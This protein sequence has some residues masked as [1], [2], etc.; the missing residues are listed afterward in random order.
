MK[1][2]TKS[3]KKKLKRILKELDYYID[4]VGPRDLRGYKKDVKEL[5]EKL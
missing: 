5:L 2:L 1:D 4:D 3:D